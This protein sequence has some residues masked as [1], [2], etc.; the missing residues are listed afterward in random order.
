MDL[1][2]GAKQTFVMMR[3][4]ARDGSAKIVRECTYPLTGVG[5]VSRIYTDLAVFLIDGRGIVVRELFGTH[6]G[7]L[8][9]LLDLPL[10]DGTRP[11]GAPDVTLEGTTS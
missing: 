6:L 3:L 9:D 2:L 10:V 5:C 11:S 1:A 4:L 7:R 8:R